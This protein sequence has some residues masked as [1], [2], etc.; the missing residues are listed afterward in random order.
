MAGLTVQAA[1]SMLSSILAGGVQLHLYTVAPTATTTGTE[2]SG[3]GYLAQTIT[4]AS[5]TGGS[6]SQAADVFF[7]SATADYGSTIVAWA[8]TDTSGNPL[9]F[10]DFSATPLSVFNGDQITFPAGTIIM[11]VS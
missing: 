9:V 2:M 8:V 11:T 6:A 5:P 10:L 4:F 1:N 7:P 3:A